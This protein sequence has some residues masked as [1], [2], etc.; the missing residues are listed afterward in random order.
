MPSDYNQYWA[1]IVVFVRTL[2]SNANFES[3]TIDLRITASTVGDIFN[4]RVTTEEFGAFYH[5]IPVSGID[6]NDDVEFEIGNPSGT[7]I[8]TGGNTDIEL[9]LPEHT[10]APD[11][12]VIESFPDNP[13][14]NA[15]GE[16]L[17]SNVDILVNG[18]TVATDVGSG[19]FE[20]VVDIT[21]TLNEDTFNTIA[22]SSDSTGHIRLTAYSETYKQIG[23][24]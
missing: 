21:G 2:D 9:W 4:E 1:I 13:N 20:T 18:N 7:D 6:Q 22:A 24:E 16:L 14:A 10:H 11:P 3:Q 15:N 17:P 8:A 5:W 19:E 23:Q 12:G